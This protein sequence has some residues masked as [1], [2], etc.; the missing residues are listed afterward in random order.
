[1][2]MRGYFLNVS[3]TPWMIRYDACLAIAYHQHCCDAKF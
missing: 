3:G 1:M 2:Q